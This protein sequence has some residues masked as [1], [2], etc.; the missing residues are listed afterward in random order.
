M[1]DRR[2]ELAAWEVYECGK[3]WREATKVE[4]P[5]PYVPEEEAA[6]AEG[7][8][9]EQS[10]EEA[11]AAA[12][13][14]AAAAAAAIAAAAESAAAIAAWSVRAEIESFVA[15]VGGD[16]VLAALLLKELPIPD[17][18]VEEVEEAEDGT[19]GEAQE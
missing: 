7:E 1:R 17:P 13:A 19:G 10:E 16:E 6:E 8:A 2:Y 4:P 11:A 15:T 3:A 18:P 5:Q 12:E 14:K 9:E